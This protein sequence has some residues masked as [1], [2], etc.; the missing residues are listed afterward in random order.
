MMRKMLEKLTVLSGDRLARH[1]GMDPALD[2]P[3]HGVERGLVRD[4]TRREYELQGAEELQ[5]ERHADGRDEGRDPGGIPQGLVRHPLDGERQQRADEHREKDHREGPDHKGDSRGNGR[6]EHLRPLVE[7]ELAHRVET[8]E[9]PHHENVTV[10]EVDQLHDAVHHRVA[11]RDQRVHTPELQSVQDILEELGGVPRQVAHQHVDCEHGNN[12]KE[13][14]ADPCEGRAP[15]AGNPA[16]GC[17]EVA[18][19]GHVFSGCESVLRERA[20]G[21]LPSWSS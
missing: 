16:R 20:A 3:G 7:I 19:L 17:R 21:R 2:V 13:P 6:E 11:E 14:V 8:G 1:D 4:E 12:K 18:F 5:E 9:R 10:R 15:S